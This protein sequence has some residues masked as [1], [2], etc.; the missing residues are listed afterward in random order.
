MGPA[1][2]CNS[3]GQAARAGRRVIRLSRRRLGPTRTTKGEIMAERLPQTDA[4]ASLLKAAIAELLRTIP[5]TWAEFDFD[6]LTVIQNNALFLLT[7]AGLVERRGWLRSTIA[8]HPTAFEVRF[9][10]T[11]EGGFAKAITSSGHRI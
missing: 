8:N 5:E 10:A 3:P 11:G 9:Q 1:D 4:E 2:C 6:R 7:A